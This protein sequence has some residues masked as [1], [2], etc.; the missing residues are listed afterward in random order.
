MMPGYRHEDKSHL[1][2]VNAI[3]IGV[4]IIVAAIVAWS[5]MR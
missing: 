4:L 3:L 5:V 2:R 1:A